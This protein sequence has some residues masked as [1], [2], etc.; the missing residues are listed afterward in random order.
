MQD[1]IDILYKINRI[2]ENSYDQNF[3]RQLDNMP[4]IDKAQNLIRYISNNTDSVNR[5]NADIL[6]N[7]LKNINEVNNNNNGNHNKNKKININRNKNFQNIQKNKK[8]DNS[9]NIDSNSIYDNDSLLSKLK[10]FLKS[11]NDE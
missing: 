8:Y 4:P 10:F 1:I 11:L 3:T 5:K 2:K 6:I 9:S 7:I